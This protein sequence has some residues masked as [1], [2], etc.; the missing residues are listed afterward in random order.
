MDYAVTKR[1][2]PSSSWLKVSVR[3]R[4]KQKAASAPPPA[5]RK[6]NKRAS[7]LKENIRAGARSLSK[8]LLAAGLLAA[9]YQ[10]GV[11][12]TTSPRFAVSRVT[13][14]GNEMVSRQDLR[15][16][17]T[18]VSGKNIFLLDLE[19]ASSDFKTHPWVQTASVRKVF[20][21]TL[22]I[23]LKERQP[24]A[25]I[26]LGETYVMDSHGV[27]LA[28]DGE[29][30][31]HLPLVIHFERRSAGPGQTVANRT[32]VESLKVMRELN[33]L[34]FFR[35]D[36]IDRVQIRPGARVEFASGKEDTKVFM[37][38]NA[39]RENFRNFRMLMNTLNKQ[40]QSIDRI[41][42]SFKDQVVVRYR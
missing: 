39:L 27:L 2:K 37:S 16:W 13:V 12:L 17:L 38:L 6:T 24:F 35:A 11:F 32:V 34:P 8:G 29:A 22:H 36:A 41:D 15:K 4:K 31:R 10:A 30:Y 1:K 21:Q 26:R 18:S 33:R 9:L 40:E 42:L 23:H 28:G 25:R 14:T 5:R 20:P 7:R 3:Q 19:A